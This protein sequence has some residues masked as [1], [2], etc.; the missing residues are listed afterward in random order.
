MKRVRRVYIRVAY[1]ALAI[2]ALVMTDRAFVFAAR[3]GVPAALLF[4]VVSGPLLPLLG[5]GLAPYPGLRSLHVLAGGVLLLAVVYR[6]FAWAVTG[7]RTVSRWARPGRRPRISWPPRS[8]TLAR[9]VLAGLYGLLFA[10][11]LWSGVERYVG[12][13]F[14]NPIVPVLSAL[15]LGLAHRLLAPYYVAALLVVWFVKSRV[16]WRVLLDQLRRP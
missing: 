11:M 5:G 6:V 10:L 13:R 14:G 8:G 15:E 2:A 7:A 16:A 3:W 12:Q 9:I 4:V 1:A